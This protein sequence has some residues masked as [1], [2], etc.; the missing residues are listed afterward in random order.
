M[1]DR[2]VAVVILNW[3]AAALTIACLDSLKAAAYDDVTIIVVDNDSRDGSADLIRAVHPDVRLIENPSNRGFGAG[4]NPGIA[5]ALADNV[6]YLWLLNNDTTVFPRTLPALVDVAESDRAVGAVGSVL[7]HMDSPSR[8][9]AFGGG[10]VSFWTGLERPILGP[11]AL[12]ETFFLTAASILLRAS[13]LSHVG[14]FD[15]DFFMYWED[16]D[17]SMRLRKAG[18]KIA[19]AEDSRVLHLGNASSS[20][21]VRSALMFHESAARFFKKHAPIALVPITV[22]ATLRAVRR[23]AKGQFSTAAAIVRGSFLAKR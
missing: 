20:S 1:S 16:V 4:N 22:A 8:L 2:S 9:Q 10:C 21:S 5:A 3:R 19:V 13:A 14:L 7:Y 6:A 11:G 18:W 23:I 17:L 15:E 12:P